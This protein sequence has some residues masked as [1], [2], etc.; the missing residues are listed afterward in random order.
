[1]SDLI[2][3]K[4]YRQVLGV[5][6]IILLS[7]QVFES[8]FGLVGGLR[9]EKAGP[10]IGVRINAEPHFLNAEPPLVKY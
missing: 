4:L 3:V 5:L 7:L 8:N 6:A 9:L 2:I 10:R 1:V